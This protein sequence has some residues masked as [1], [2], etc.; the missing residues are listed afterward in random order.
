VNLERR[1]W[2]PDISMIAD[3][4]IEDYR[5]ASPDQDLLDVVG[6]IT[7]WKATAAVYGEEITEDD[8]ITLVAELAHRVVRRAAP[9]ADPGR[10]SPDPRPA[11]GRR[12]RHR[13]RAR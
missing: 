8:W 7:S 2:V 1:R 4:L 11:A 5:D 13:H 9:V 6:T 3:Q 12:D 10:A